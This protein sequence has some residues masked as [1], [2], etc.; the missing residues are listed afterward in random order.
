MEIKTYCVLSDSY[1]L[2]EKE[3][4]EESK[5]WTWVQA[6]ACMPLELFL[7]KFQFFLTGKK[8]RVCLLYC[9]VL[10]PLTL[11]GAVPYHHLTLS[12]SK[13]CNL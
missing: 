9:F 11:L 4:Y 12:L 6:P 10:S 1:G 2:Q 8:P 13:S 5:N 3:K 7:T